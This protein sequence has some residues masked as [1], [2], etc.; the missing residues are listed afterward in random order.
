M[1]ILGGWVFLM[2]EVPLYEG[3]Q[4]LERPLKQ[5]HVSVRCQVVSQLAS[6]RAQPRERCFIDL[7]S[8]PLEHT[9]APPPLS[10]SLCLFD[11]VRRGGKGGDL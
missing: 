11:A 9:R 1:V 2:S 8:H 10:A 5:I 7:G 4:W 3:A 6:S